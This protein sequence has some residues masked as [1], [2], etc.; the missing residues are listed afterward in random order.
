MRSGSAG[1]ARETLHD[2]R[3]MPLGTSDVELPSAT[4]VPELVQYIIKGK[5][6]T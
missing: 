2:E 6:K 3:L 1:P 4:K 5:G